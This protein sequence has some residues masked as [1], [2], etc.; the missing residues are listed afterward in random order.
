MASYEEFFSY[1]L[2]Q[3]RLSRGWTRSF[4]AWLLGVS[5]STLRRWEDGS[6]IPQTATIWRVLNQIERNETSVGIGG[7][8]QL[9]NVFT[10]LAKSLELPQTNSDEEKILKLEKTLKNS[11]LRA[12]QT[13]FRF[14]SKSRSIEPVP[15]PDD[16]ALF[17]NSKA[18]DVADL[19]ASLA[20]AARDMI[21]DIERA[22]LNSTRLV[23]HLESYSDEC[24]APHPNPRYLQHKGSIIKAALLDE[25]IR[26]ALGDW[27]E[28]ALNQFVD[29]HNELMRRY[30]GEALARAREIEVAEIDEVVVRDAPGLLSDALASISDANRNDADRTGRVDEK[31]VAIFTDLLRELQDTLE[32]VE[33]AN[34]PENKE[35]LLKRA[36]VVVKHASVLTGRL[37]L[38]ITGAVIENG[39]NLGSLGMLLELAHPG[40]LAFIYN[41]F[42]RAIPALPPFPI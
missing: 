21:P 30:F 17:R 23:R 16:L 7:F 5:A 10:N 36:R 38:R 28:I 3:F 9:R 18:A 37:L 32:A 42:A 15:F 34:S 20:R 26:G 27:D 14:S 6:N 4:V 24:T 29:D 12:S 25:Q 40:S 33:R 31:A 19:I 2:K 1:D 22:N 35:R 41:L 11:I 8:D 39:A 13:D